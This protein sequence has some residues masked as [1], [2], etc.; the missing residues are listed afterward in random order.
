MKKP[1]I[2]ILLHLFILSIAV[3]CSADDNDQTQ[4][5]IND[6][7]TDNGGGNTDDNDN[8]DDGNVSSTVF[9]RLVGNTFRQIEEPGDCATCQDEINY[10]IFSN[11][12]IS[13]FIFIYEI[14]FHAFET[15]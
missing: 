12:K 15:E 2:L 13:H 6:N 7:S 1:L 14:M 3:S 8:S 10:Y 9:E 5:L 11:R 4:E